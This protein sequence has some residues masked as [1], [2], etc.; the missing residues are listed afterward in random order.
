MTGYIYKIVN[1]INGKVYVGKTTKTIQERF[2]D[3]ILDSKRDRCK[4]RP[5]YRAFNKYG[6]ENFSIEMIEEAPLEKLSE[7]EIY[8]IGYYHSYK[9]GYNATIG[10]DSKVLYNYN[11]IISLILNN[12]T[13]TEIIEKIGCCRDIVYEIAKRNNLKIYQ[14]EN[15]FEKNKKK[16]K[17]LDKSSNYLRSFSSIAEA[18]KWLL[19]NNYIKQYNGGIRAHI[20]EVCR[21]IR[22]TAYQFKWEYE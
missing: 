15:N 11:E 20:S 2:R 12:K 4:N 14:P 21:G 13:V 22:K 8:W 5:L 6:I 1:L 3:H 16:V 10:G 17:Q 7:K 9:E 19:E 18:G